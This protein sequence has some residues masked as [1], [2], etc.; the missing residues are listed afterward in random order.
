MHPTQALQLTC[1]ALA[2]EFLHCGDRYAHRLLVCTR[3][4]WHCLAESVEGSAHDIWPPS[5]ALQSA[6][7]EHR[8]AGPVALLVGM[9]G[10]SHYSAAVAAQHHHRLDFD[11]ACRVAA[12]PSR[13]GSTYRLMPAVCALP[14]HDD[15][16]DGPAAMLCLHEHPVARIAP[17]DDSTLLHPDRRTLQI[18]PVDLHAVG[19]P[20]TIRWRY[21]VEPCVPQ[22]C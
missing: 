10:R 18:A 8:S 7:I 15:A 6:H 21:T 16:A 9:A 3:G 14:R 1:G 19:V 2:V 17:A 20:A 4:T 22:R 12:V 13:L 11:L 5:A